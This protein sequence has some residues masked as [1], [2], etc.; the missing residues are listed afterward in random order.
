MEVARER[1]RFRA[2]GRD[3]DL[4]ALVARKIAENACIVNVVFND[5][6]RGISG[7]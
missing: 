6:Q 3:Q 1:Q 7:L 4:E 2:A 5:Q